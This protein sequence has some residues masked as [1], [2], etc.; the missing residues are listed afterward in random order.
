MCV[1]VFFIFF[2][3]ASSFILE[4][5]SVYFVFVDVNVVVTMAYSCRLSI[6]LCFLAYIFVFTRVSLPWG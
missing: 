3:T 1:C 6:R 2:T 4:V 5:I